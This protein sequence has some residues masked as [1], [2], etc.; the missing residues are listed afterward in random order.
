MIN[1][2][3]K[4]VMKINEKKSLGR[5]VSLPILAF[6]FGLVT[7]CNDS[8]SSQNLEDYFDIGSAKLLIPE[9]YLIAPLPATIVGD[10]N[11]YDSSRAASVNL[12][13]PLLDLGLETAKETRL[14]KVIIVYLTSLSEAGYKGGFAQDND[15]A[16]NGAGLYSDRIVT[17]D[18]INGLYRIYAESGY[19]KL[20]H[21]FERSP[22]EPG[23]A[24]ENW[25]AVCM[26]GPSTEE[27]PDLS[28]VTCTAAVDADEVGVAV[29]F[30]F[31]AINIGLLKQIEKNLIKMLLTWKK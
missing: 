30:G 5:R 10:G 29:K 23:T 12:E 27:A 9:E 6:F 13:I 24:R 15:D 18:P 14:A 19:P 11:G 28:N 21:Y 26:V 17:F 3:V 7:G 22:S 4:D 8:A 25:V 16:W 2:G 31:A 20:W 1:Y